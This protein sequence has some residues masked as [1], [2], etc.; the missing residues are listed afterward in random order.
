[1]SYP[2]PPGYQPPPGYAAPP[3]PTH[4]KATLS[5][6]LGIISLVACGLFTGIPAMITGRTARREIAAS[7][8]R[9]GGDGLA[10]AGFITGLIGTVLSGL[11]VVAVVILF[12]LGAVVSGSFESTCDE[13][14][15]DGV[16]ARC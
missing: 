7:H 15:S 8:G 10:Q 1:M 2:P 16:Y 12:A 9:L 6:V 11:G 3:P 5:L 13:L 14:G 4:S